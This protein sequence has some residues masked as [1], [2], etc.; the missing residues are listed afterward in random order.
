MGIKEAIQS[1]FMGKRDFE[2]VFGDGDEVLRVL[3]KHSLDSFIKSIPLVPGELV[4][5]VKCANRKIKRGGG[6]Q[7]PKDRVESSLWLT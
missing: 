3:K 5:H 2:E 6:A 1:P 7:Y 4:K